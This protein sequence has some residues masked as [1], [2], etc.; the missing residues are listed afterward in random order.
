MESADKVQILAGA[1]HI[2]LE[3]D[4]FIF[5]LSKDTS[6]KISYCCLAQFAWVASL[7]RC[8][9]RLTSVLDMT[10]NNLMDEV[11]VFK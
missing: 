8:E 6:S 10:L 11:P 3:R 4:D 1:A 5:F 7:Q 2:H 9:A